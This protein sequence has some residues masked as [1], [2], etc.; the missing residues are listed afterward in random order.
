MKSTE[1]LDRLDRAHEARFMAVGAYEDYVA[2]VTSDVT[3]LTAALRAVLTLHVLET[4][5]EAT[6]C[7]VCGWE[8]GYPCPTVTAIESALAAEPQP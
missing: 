5:E 4:G 2:V 7:F 6:D 8:S 3:K 1:R